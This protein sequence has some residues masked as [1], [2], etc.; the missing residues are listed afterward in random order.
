MG[1]LEVASTPNIESDFSSSPKPSMA[2]PKAAAKG[3]PP[4]VSSA[5]ADEFIEVLTVR[6]GRAAA[7]ILRSLVK[8]PSSTE[9]EPE[10]VL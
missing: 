8:G 2:A 7:S 4:P 3:S 9:P 5:I 6:D 10:S 1:S